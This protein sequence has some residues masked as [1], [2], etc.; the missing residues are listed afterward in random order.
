MICFIYNWRVIRGRSYAKWGKKRCRVSAKFDIT[1]ILRSLAASRS[2]L[3]WP[4]VRSC[5]VAFSESRSCGELCRVGSQPSIKA[6][7]YHQRQL[8][9]PPF[10]FG[11]ARLDGSGSILANAASACMESAWER[12]C[13]PDLAM[14]SRSTITTAEE[15]YLVPQAS[16]LIGSRPC[17][18]A[19]DCNTEIR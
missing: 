14:S 13:L 16:S 10:D 12:R 4:T 18:L 11:L 15:Q 5:L 9:R 2:L 3:A 1:C 19:G 7:L 17:P 6:G 8:F